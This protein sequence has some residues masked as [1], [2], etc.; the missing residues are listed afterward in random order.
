MPPDQRMHRSIQL[1]KQRSANSQLKI[2]PLAGLMGLSE[3]VPN[4]LVTN[5]NV[6]GMSK[7]FC[8]E[9]VLKCIAHYI[10]VLPDHSTKL[11]ACPAYIPS[12]LLIL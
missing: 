10:M 8:D 9:P 1:Q 5:L 4:C 12:L 6:S 11:T 7:V 3:Y 2:M